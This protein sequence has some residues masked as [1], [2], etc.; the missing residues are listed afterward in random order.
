MQKFCVVPGDLSPLELP[1]CFIAN[2]TGD[3]LWSWHHGASA[4]VDGGNIEPGDGHEMRGYSFV[5]GG[6]K[7]HS[8]IRGGSGVDFHK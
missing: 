2:D 3:E 6:K 5:T 1:R 7:D 8:V 4:E